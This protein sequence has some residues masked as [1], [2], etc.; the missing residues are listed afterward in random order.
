MS[1]SQKNIMKTLL[2]HSFFSNSFTSCSELDDDSLV[3]LLQE[4]L[5]DKKTLKADFIQQVNFTYSKNQTYQGM[6]LYFYFKL[7]QNL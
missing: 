6:Y 5:V 1:S 3:L 2:S 4:L 7:L